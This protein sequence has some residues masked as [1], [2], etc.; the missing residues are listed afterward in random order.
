M[1]RRGEGG[2]RLRRGFGGAGLRLRREYVFLT[3]FYVADRGIGRGGEDGGGVERRCVGG[4][5]E[6]E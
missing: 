4:E 6:N 5:W 3:Y 2:R 1:L